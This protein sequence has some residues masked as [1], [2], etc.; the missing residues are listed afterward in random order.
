MRGAEAPGW[1][2][3]TPVLSVVLSLAARAAGQGASLDPVTW[4]PTIID[5]P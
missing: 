5:L 4:W 2:V 1:L 3:P